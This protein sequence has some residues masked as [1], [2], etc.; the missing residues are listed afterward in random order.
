[1]SNIYRFHTAEDERVCGICGPL[2]GALV[3]DDP[4]FHPPMHVGCRCSVEFLYSD[5]IE[6]EDGSVGPNPEPPPSGSPGVGFEPY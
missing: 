5:T 2:D 1:M 4:A 6:Y 3:D